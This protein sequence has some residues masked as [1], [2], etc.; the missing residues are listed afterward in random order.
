VSEAAS[1]N[2]FALPLKSVDRLSRCLAR[3]GVWL[4]RFRN[5]LELGANVVLLDKD[6][7]RD[8]PPAGIDDRLRDRNRVDLLNGDI[9]RL[10]RAADEIDDR[11]L[12]IVG[13][14]ELHRPQIDVDLAVGEGLHA[15]PRSRE[16]DS[17]LAPPFGPNLKRKGAPNGFS[18]S[19]RD[20]G[21]VAG[22]AAVA[23][24]R[25]TELAAWGHDSTWRANATRRRSPRRRRRTSARAH[26]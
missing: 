2:G 9:E 19:S 23:Q 6:V 3:G 20:T 18:V 15:P 10:P 26:R 8:A 21:R 4:G 12:E 25:C 22:R 7:D 1:P 24:Q 16:I 13:G 17:M 5:L 11:R 14:P